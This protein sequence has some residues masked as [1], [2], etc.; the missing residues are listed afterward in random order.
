MAAAA[1]KQ[2]RQR[3]SPEA[4]QL[5]YEMMA[6]AW[7]TGF[8]VIFGVGSVCS[9]VT[10][11]DLKGLWQVAVVWGFGVGLAIY[12]TASVSG[13]HLNPAV[14]LALA[15]WRSADFP[16]WKLGPYIFA[17]MFG[18]VVAAFINLA[19]FGE[20][21]AK[22][23][24]AN[25]V[26]RGDPGSVYSA[27]AFGEYFP[28]PGPFAAEWGDGTRDSGDMIE[29]P[30]HAFL[31]EAWG[32]FVLMFVI[33]CLTDGKQAALKQKE[34]VPFLIGFCV[35]C[36][37]SVYAPLTQAGWNPARD[38]GPRLVAWMVGY[39]S[40][41]I[42]G[43]RGGFW[44]FILGP[45]VGA[46]L[47]VPVYD[48]TI[49]PGLPKPEENGVM[50]K[51]KDGKSV[52]CCFDKDGRCRPIDGMGPCAFAVVAGRPVRE[53]ALAGE[54]TWGPSYKHNVM[55][56]CNHNSCRSQM[57][58]GWL[59]TLRGNASVGVASAGI[60]GGTA[61]KE[62]AI[63]VMKEVGID[64][65]TF[66]SDPMT[67]YSPNSFDVVI[68]CC[69]CGS[70]LDGEKQVWKQRDIFADW[71]LDDPPA[72]DPGDLS[73]YRRVRDEI[74]AKVEKLLFQLNDDPPSS[75]SV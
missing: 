70:K 15:I 41:A 59:R 49:A 37:I 17:Q 32:T 69:G 57:A 50:C 58:D 67:D 6:E 48:F 38:F 22:Y 75:A 43:P 63:T 10:S 71:N 27:R 23:D 39:G 73:E 9:A 31:V 25:G 51:T 16:R 52:R 24:K 4:R 54:V 19:M 8:I 20:Y 18:S 5:F 33:L 40:V 42:P 55:F 34:M 60:V 3:F 65:S 74:K 14:S 56:L 11:G 53:G 72:T 61:V 29:H 62:G 47:A 30:A 46:P 13:A 66:T 68:S 64:I 12:C 35:A 28:N 1:A 36:L 2:P 44:V 45:L 7:G 21:F 26:Q